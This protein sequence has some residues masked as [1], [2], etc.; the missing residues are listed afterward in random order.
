[1]RPGRPFSSA[2][3]LTA[4]PARRAE[5]ALAAAQASLE[6]GAF[7][8]ALGVLATAEAGPLDNLQRARVD[9]L[10]GRIASASNF[11]SAASAC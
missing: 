7:D 5:R 1:V 8:A 2:R 9:L 6:A 11:G 10:R 4:D 3:A